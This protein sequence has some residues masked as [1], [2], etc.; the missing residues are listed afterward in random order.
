M[1]LSNLECRVCLAE[2]AGDTKSILEH[3]MKDKVHRDAALAVAKESNGAIVYAYRLVTEL[4]EATPLI[5]DYA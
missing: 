4:C 2:I 5:V 3:F 1:V